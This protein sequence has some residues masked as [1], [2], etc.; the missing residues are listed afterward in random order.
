MQAVAEP[1]KGTLPCPR[2]VAG[3]LTK[4]PGFTG[5]VGSAAGAKNDDARAPSDGG[6]AEDMVTPHLSQLLDGCRHIATR[7][8]EQR[9][10]PDRGPPE[11]AAAS[12]PVRGDL[13]ENVRFNGRAGSGH[14][15][16]SLW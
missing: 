15:A 1:S 13:V 9:A 6:S 14:A 3:G 2:R 7:L 16:W 10:S 12:P 5:H 11:A 8:A 4:V